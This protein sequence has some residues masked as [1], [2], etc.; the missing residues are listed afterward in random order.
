MGKNKLIKKKISKKLKSKNKASK[1]L[2]SVIMGSRSDYPVMEKALEVLK[3]L[4]IAYEVQ[5]VSAHRTPERMYAYAKDC[6]RKGIQVII[7]G[8]GGAAHLPG[9]VAG[10][11]VLP[12]IGVPV[13]TKSLKGL[14]S[15]LSVAQ[16]PA[17]V[18][19]ASVAIDAAYNAALLAARILSISRPA[20]TQKLLSLKSRQAKKT[21]KASQQISQL[22]KHVLSLK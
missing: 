10:L 17:G 7:A 3:S 11:C 9:M 20:L 8:A 12:V 19:V 6:G 14:D 21:L 2:V 22:K 18:P 16:M 13:S 15:L 4:S 5:I 1:A